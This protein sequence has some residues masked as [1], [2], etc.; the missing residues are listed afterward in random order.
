MDE[1]TLNKSVRVFLKKV[2]IN[3]Q[4]EIEKAV[5]ERAEAGQLEQS[6]IP[7]T[8]TLHVPDLDLEIEIRDDL[9]VG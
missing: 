7:A 6:R 9:D 1:D 8:M 4:R 2:G 3:S 5:R